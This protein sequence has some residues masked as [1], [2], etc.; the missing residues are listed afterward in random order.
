MNVREKNKTCTNC[1]QSYEE[2]VTFPLCPKCMLTLKDY[3]SFVSESK[4]S[5]FYQ[6]HRAIDGPS[7]GN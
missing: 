7:F 5:A 1:N 2:S 3:K 4:T 6:P